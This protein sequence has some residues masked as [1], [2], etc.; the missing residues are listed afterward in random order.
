MDETTRTIALDKADAVVRKIGYP[1]FV[2]KP[3]LVD[4]RYEK[5][6]WP[7]ELSCDTTTLFTYLSSI[8]FALVVLLPSCIHV[9]CQY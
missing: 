8:R 4:D 6:W 9:A 7:L 5:V 1:D 3:A 2:V